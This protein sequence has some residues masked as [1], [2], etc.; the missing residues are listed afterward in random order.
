MKI[1]TEILQFLKYLKPRYPLLSGI[2][3]A[4]YHLFGQLIIQNHYL[5]TS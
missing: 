5:T 2:E 4:G 1:Q 3:T